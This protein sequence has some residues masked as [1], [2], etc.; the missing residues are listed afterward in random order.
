MPF[1]NE[2]AARLK[3]PDTLNEIRVRRTNGSGEGTVQGKKVPESIDVIWFIVKSEGKEVPIAQ[4]LRFPI[5]KWAAADAAKKWLKDNEMKFTNFEKAEPKKDNE[6][7]LEIKSLSFEVKAFED[8]ESDK[9]KFKAMASTFGNIDLTGD[10]IMPGA[11]TETIKKAKKTGRMPKVFTDHWRENRA[12]VLKSMIETENGLEIE[13]EFLNT[14]R[15]KDTYEEV[16]AGALSDMSIGFRILDV[17]YPDSPKEKLKGIQRKI[18]R[19]DLMEISFVP[20]PAN[21]KANVLAVK[22]RPQNIREAEELLIENGF[23]LNEAK[24]LLS[25]GYKGLSKRDDEESHLR[26]VDV[27]EIS[28]S[29][30]NFI[31]ELKGEK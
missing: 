9:R 10:V 14:T 12:G 30:D 19:I 6:D 4:S 17:E 24:C 1:P 29:L 8:E 22:Q 11:F 31:N 20:F 5:K 26:D 15:G 13:G 25:E 16:K 23:S 27:K 18:K 2:H 21:P 28:N 7:E 3:N